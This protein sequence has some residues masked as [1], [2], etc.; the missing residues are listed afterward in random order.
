MVVGFGLVVWLGG[1]SRHNALLGDNHGLGLAHGDGLRPTLVLH[2]RGQ[3]DGGWLRAVGGPASH[4][5]VLGSS[6]VL[7]VWVRGSRRRRWRSSANL[8]ESDLVAG[9]VWSSGTSSNTVVVLELLLGVV[10]LLAG[11]EL[12]SNVE[13]ALSIKSDLGR[14]NSGANLEESGFNADVAW[15]LALSMSEVLGGSVV[16]KGWTSALHNLE[17]V[18]AGALVDWRDAVAVD[19]V[20]VGYNGEVHGL[21]SDRGGEQSESEVLHCGCDGRMM[22]NEL[23]DFWASFILFSLLWL[24]TVHENSCFAAMR[25]GSCSTPC[26]A[27]ASASTVVFQSLFSC[28]W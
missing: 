14:R 19:V 8:L 16:L 24:A 18:D 22:M 26:E 6:V 25:K 11:P 23:R 10:E 12:F 3:G 4:G 28:Y 20:A 27:R 13:K 15:G 5:D 2:A 7:V 17:V 21:S 1:G 9:V